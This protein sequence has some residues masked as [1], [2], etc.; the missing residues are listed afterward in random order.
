MTWARGNIAAL[1]LSQQIAAEERPATAEEQ[2]ILA[3]YVGW[4]ATKQIFDWTND[5]WEPLRKELQEVITDTEF[6]SAL[7]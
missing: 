4:G 2:E 6:N 3:K 7:D 1:R 5:A